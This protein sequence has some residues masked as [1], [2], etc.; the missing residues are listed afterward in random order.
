MSALG[1]FVRSVEGRRG[2]RCFQ[3]ANRIRIHLKSDR[4]HRGMVAFAGVALGLVTGLGPRAVPDGASCK[5]HESFGTGILD[6]RC[7]FDYCRD[8]GSGVWLL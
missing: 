4:A 6:K 3:Q 2:M 5:T 8:R 7:R 1:G